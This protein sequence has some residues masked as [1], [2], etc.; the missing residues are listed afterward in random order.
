M[1]DFLIVIPA[2]YASQRYPGKP[3]AELRGAGGTAKSLIRRSWDAACRVAAPARVRVATDSEEIRQ[4]A[5]AFGAQ[6][7]WT[8]VECRN[9]TERCAEVLQG[10]DDE[11]EIVVNL[12]GDAP[13]TPDWFVQGLI[14]AM[15]QDPDIQVATPVMRVSRS[16]YDKLV[17]DEKEGIVGGTFGAISSAGNALYFSKRVIPHFDP[18]KFADDALPVFLHIGLY[19]YRP[20]ALRRYAATAPAPLEELEGLEQLRFL[21]SGIPI[22][23]VEV[24]PPE[25]EIWELNNPSDIPHIEKAL[26]A[27]GV[28]SLRNKAIPPS[29]KTV[30][31]RSIRSTA[32]SFVTCGAASMTEYRRSTVS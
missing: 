15:R 24:R 5:E 16:L 9:G 29:S 8:S 28:E 23:A 4:A 22:K 2:R 12:Q 10:L 14:D 20:E 21:D 7:A 26:A 18:T 31:R 32:W 25:W 30:W 17:A 19:A 13:L 11:P 3:L 27:M 1:S 6:V